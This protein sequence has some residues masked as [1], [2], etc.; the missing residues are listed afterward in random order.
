MNENIA[1][2]LLNSYFL[3]MKNSRT[4]LTYRKIIADAENYLTKQFLS[5]DKSDVQRFLNLQ[6]KLYLDHTI[7]YTTYCTRFYILRSYAAFLVDNAKRCGLTYEDPF[8]Y[9]I[10]PE[11]A[12]FLNMYRIPDEKKLE[13]VLIC[14]S[15]YDKNLSLALWLIIRCGIRISHLI[16]LKVSDVRYTKKQCSFYIDQGN[17]S[18]FL[19]C[20]NDLIQYVEQFMIG[21]RKNDFLLLN[22]RNAPF[23]IRRLEKQYKAA[24]NEINDT[25]T[26]QD[27]RNGAIATMLKYGTKQEVAEKL[28]MQ[29]QW[30][31]RFDE[32]LVTHDVDYRNIIIEY[33]KGDKNGE[34]EKKNCF[35][36]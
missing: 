23:T 3:E 25:P 35:I 17:K 34:S 20:P 6:M 5:F 18:F 28:H 24:T 7:T 21:K 30:L 15:A 14:A 26:L 33:Q 29:V 27:V 2:F 22:K 8:L 10:P 32:Y 13:Q 12:R 4:E 11:Y 1:E 36:N 16:R 19:E 9:V 31:Y